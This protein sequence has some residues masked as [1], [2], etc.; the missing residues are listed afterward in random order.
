MYLGDRSGADLRSP[1]SSFCRSLPF[2]L[3]DLRFATSSPTLSSLS[4]LLSQVFDIP[5]I[6]NQPFEARLEQLNALFPADK[7]GPVQ[8]VKHELC[9]GI[10]D[11]NE[12]LAAVQKVDG[13]G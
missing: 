7:E 12:K 2:A 13:E 1:S 9:K 6:G 8:V 4:P 3:L 11:L 10:E 5:S